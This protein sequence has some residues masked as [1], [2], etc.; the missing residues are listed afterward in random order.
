MRDSFKAATTEQ[1]S[2]ED[3]MAR[4]EQAIK[5]Y[6][7]ENKMP[8]CSFL[9]AAPID[10][11]KDAPELEECFSRLQQK[12]PALDHLDLKDNGTVVLD[13]EP[14]PMPKPSARWVVKPRAL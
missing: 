10:R 14:K 9:P 8:F 6:I 4:A 1:F 11:I 12:Y 5:Y 2:A 3:F 7:T 13:T